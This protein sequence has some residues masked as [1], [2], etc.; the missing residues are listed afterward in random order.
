MNR[1]ARF[2]L[3]GLAAAGVAVALLGATAG[4]AQGQTD[5]GTTPP[6]TAHGVNFL[7]KTQLDTSFCVQV[8]AGTGEGR[9]I[10]LQQCGGADTQRWAF[11]WNND[12]TNV[13]V[14]SQGM[15][16]DGRSRKGGDGLAL[17][18]QK[19]R[20]GDAWRYSYTSLGQIR[21]VRNGKCLQVSA[22]AAN[23]PVTLVDCDSSKKNQLWILAH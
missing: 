4:P 21:D 6:T 15:C 13:V 7:V 14:D 22:A 20:F 1:F 8:A 17:P 9:T 3:A 16:L 19:C 10:T 12:D 11:T 23:A 2:G 18:V 5:A